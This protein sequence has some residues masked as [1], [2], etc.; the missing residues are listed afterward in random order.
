MW[1][2]I[3]ECLGTF[4]SS[5]NMP[6]LYLNYYSHLSNNHGGWNKCGGGAKVAK[7][8][9]VKVGINTEGGIL[10][11]WKKLVGYCNE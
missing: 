11:F 8:K 4:T 5:K 1:L 7:P 6:N 2:N 9:N 3:R 10:F